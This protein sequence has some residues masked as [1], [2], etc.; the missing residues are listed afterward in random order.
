MSEKPSETRDEPRNAG[1]RALDP[2]Y[3]DEL[4]D[5][6]PTGL[7]AEDWAARERRRRQ[8]WLN[9]PSEDERIAW[10]RRE[11]RRRASGSRSYEDPA[12]LGPTDEEVEAWA[13]RE[14]R[15]R[16]AW[17]DGPS[18][19]E[20]IAWARG[21]RRRRRDRDESWWER[22]W[23]EG[24]SRGRSTDLD[25]EDDVASRLSR[26]AWLATEGAVEALVN[27]PFRMWSRLVDAGRDWEEEEYYPR[28]R[29]RIRYRDE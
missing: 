19:D 13:E 29:R 24:L 15:R 2:L 20:K 14:R 22:P 8:A 28:R 18:E 1:S 10:A 16:Q 17:L 3:D 4:S 26:E 11:R 25:D 21:E 9:G 27:L 7:D 5:V 6:G 12:L 23:R